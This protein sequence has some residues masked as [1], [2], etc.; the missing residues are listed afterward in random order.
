[1]RSCIGIP[2]TRPAPE[3]DISKL[4]N[5]T[6]SSISVRR[7]KGNREMNLLEKRAEAQRMT[8]LG[9]SVALELP[10]L[11]RSSTSRSD[12]TSSLNIS[13]PSLLLH[14]AHSSFNFVHS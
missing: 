8:A 1:M 13:S 4:A 3:Y 12:W 14:S 2:S 6:I 9:S 10:R 7:K 5:V 11:K